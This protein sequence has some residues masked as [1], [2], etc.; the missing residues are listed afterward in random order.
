MAKKKPP[1]DQLD[2]VPVIVAGYY[3]LQK[4]R[5]EHGNRTKDLERRGIFTE[6][7]AERWYDLGGDDLRRAEQRRCAS[8]FG[9]TA[10][11]MNH[12]T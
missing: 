3:D 11:A 8:L 10:Y 2:F 4:V 6:V 1:P 12:P 5:I 7:K 9:G